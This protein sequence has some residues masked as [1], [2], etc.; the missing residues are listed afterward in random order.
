MALGTTIADPSLN[1]F[2]HVAGVLDRSASELQLYV[3]GSLASSLSFMSLGSL[4]TNIP[5]AI[6]A[7]GRTP[8][9]PTTEFFE[10]QVDEVALYNRA[11]SVSEIEQLAFISEP[12]PE[13]ATIALLGI[14]L[15]G[16]VAYGI[17][18]RRRQQAI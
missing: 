6:G 1:T 12:I 16:M 14:G 8:F 18:R 11:L 5:F 2:H 4:D 13:P 15:A 7:I 10:G 9:G 17:R 3:D